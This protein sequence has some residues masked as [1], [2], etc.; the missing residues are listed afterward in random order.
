MGT[1]G[2]DDY[3][4]RRAANR[5]GGPRTFVCSCGHSYERHSLVRDSTPS[6]PRTYYYSRCLVPGCSCDRFVSEY[7]ALMRSGAGGDE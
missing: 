2:D 4:A 7:D 5:M 1:Y 3:R 6:S